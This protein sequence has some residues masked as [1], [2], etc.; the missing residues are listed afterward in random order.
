MTRL[1]RLF[2]DYTEA[3]SLDALVTIDSTLDD[4][5]FLTRCGH[6]LTVVKANPRDYECLDPEQLDAIAR[7]F[8]GAARS[9]DE[10]ITVRQYL[11][12]RSEL[13]ISQAVHANPVVNEALQARAQYL[14]GR[15]A[16][17]Y[18]LDIY[19]VFL[20]TGWRPLESG[21]AR[22]MRWISEPRRA[23]HQV[24][25]PRAA[26][27]QLDD[28]LARARAELVQNVESLIVQLRDVVPLEVLRVDDAFRFFRRLLNYAP[29]KAESAHLKHTHF[30]GSQAADSALECHRDHLRLDDHFVQVLTLKEPPVHTFA[31]LLR[32]LQE[33]PSNFVIATEWTRAD[34][35]RVRRLIQSKRRH[36]YNSKASL[37]AHL[38]S[39]SQTSPKDQLI[40]T[41]AA[42]H[43]DALG[44]CL[45]EIE[46]NGRHFGEFSLT[47][48][49]YDLDRLRL[50]RS[51]AECFKVFAAHDARVVE[52][53]GDLRFRRE[54]AQRVVRQSVGADLL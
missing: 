6:V 7:R 17:L 37:A 15:A 33:I 53:A 8:E 22:T 20:Y 4:Q 40:D 27:S 42:A 38:S 43:V 3:G 44:A 51:A 39:T 31:H 11:L 50:Q 5:V 24:L 34:N 1:G 2:A 9:L 14:E 48:V 18:A 32:D 21:R 16:E 52:L 47:V 23:L 36:F 45:E 29:H 12:K 30:I 13:P 41:G 19:F 35:G 46:V 49:L 28:G 26:V 54:A 10:S 25:S